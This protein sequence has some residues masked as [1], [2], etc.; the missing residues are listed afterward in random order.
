M[1][2][3]PPFWTLHLATLAHDSDNHVVSLSGF[4]HDSWVF[5]FHTFV[6]E[7]PSLMCGVVGNSLFSL[8]VS[9]PASRLYRLDI[10]SS[11]SED[12][13]TGRKRLRGTFTPMAF[14]KLLIAAP[15]AVSNWIT[16]RPPSR[17]CRGWSESS[18]TDST[19]HF[20][21]HCLK[22][23]LNKLSFDLGMNLCPFSKKKKT[24]W[25]LWIMLL[26]D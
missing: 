17:V 1:L 2:T 15:T 3:G 24:F 14:L 9:E 18:N 20:Y 11:R 16:F 8:I 25:I 26:T 21:R 7:L 13:F 23:L 10:T 19:K 6:K 4:L 12:V 5:V 22:C